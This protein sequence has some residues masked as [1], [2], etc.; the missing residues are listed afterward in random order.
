[1]TYRFNYSI[2]F[3]KHHKACHMEYMECVYSQNELKINFTGWNNP[4]S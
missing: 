1:M 4:N 3:K 2:C